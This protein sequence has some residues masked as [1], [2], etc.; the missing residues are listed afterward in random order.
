MSKTWE[1]YEQVATYLLNQFREK[2]GLEFVEKK[3]V[4]SGE[5]SGVTWEIDAKGV[6]ENGEGFVIIECRR[7]TSSKIKQ[8]QI[9]AIAYRISDT[10]AEGAI[11]VSPMGFQEGASKVA[12]AENIQQ[13][14]LHPE[15]T[16]TDYVFQFLNKTMVG[17]SFNTGVLF[18]DSYGATICVS[19]HYDEE[20]NNENT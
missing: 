16:T 12:G 19:G 3:Q 11:V 14:I 7:Y 20:E 4:V 17:S 2:F 18:G 13:V 9:G 6:S 15:S 10:G 8:E 5:K 1:N